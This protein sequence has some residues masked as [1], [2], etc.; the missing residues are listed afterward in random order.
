MPTDEDGRVARECPAGDCSPAYFK[1]KPGTGVVGEQTVVYCPYCRGEAEPNDYT[2]KSQIE[3]GKQLSVRIAAS[4]T[5][6]SVLPY[7]ALIA[8]RT[9]S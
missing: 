8:E 1:V 3:Y 5:P 2:T 4:I 7:G 9:F 6:Y